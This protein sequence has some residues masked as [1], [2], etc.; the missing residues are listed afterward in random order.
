MKQSM[1]MHTPSSLAKLAAED[2][3]VTVM[4][5][6]YERTFEPLSSVELTRTIGEAAEITRGSKSQEEAK[7]KLDSLRGMT[8]FSENYKTLYSKVTNPDFVK[9]PT[10]MAT[11]YRLVR[12]T[13]MLQQGKLSSAD[14]NKKAMSVVVEHEINDKAKE[15]QI[16]EIEE[17]APPPIPC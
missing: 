9:N 16:V 4:T 11:L 17:E 3:S 5:E 2:P 8:A 15:E 7:Q 10:N 13:A 1:E 14:A 6:S 12:T